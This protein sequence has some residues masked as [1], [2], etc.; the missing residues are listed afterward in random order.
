MVGKW[1]HDAA[2]F[3]AT[4]NTTSTKIYD[5]RAV[6]EKWQSSSDEYRFSNV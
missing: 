5:E 4:I 3:T 2:A 1:L 6:V